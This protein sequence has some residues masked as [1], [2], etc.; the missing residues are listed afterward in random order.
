MEDLTWSVQYNAIVTE[1]K[2]K[3]IFQERGTEVT[4]KKLH[5][6]VLLGRAVFLEMLQV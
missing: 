1:T 3:E 6:L 4:K 2:G 5:C